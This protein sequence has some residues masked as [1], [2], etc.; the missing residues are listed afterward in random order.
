LITSGFF[1]FCKTNQKLK[2]LKKKFFL[3]F[4]YKIL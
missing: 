1:I 3:S 2:I 4:S